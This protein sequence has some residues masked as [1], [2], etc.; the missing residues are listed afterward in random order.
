MGRSV[1]EGSAE[2]CSSGEVWQ[3][4]LQLA[5]LLHQEVQEPRVLLCWSGVLKSKDLLRP[6]I[7]S[8]DFP[9]QGMLLRQHA[10]R[11]GG[12]YKGERLQPEMS[13]RLVEDLRR[14]LE[15]ER[16]RDRIREWLG[17]GTGKVLRLQLQ[18]TNPIKEYTGTCDN[19]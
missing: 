1:R 8:H 9:Q 11:R 10:T 15:D 2:P 7:L 18:V 16:L 19:I 17:N 3:V 12:P 4:G 5:G 6:Q 14:Q 13:R